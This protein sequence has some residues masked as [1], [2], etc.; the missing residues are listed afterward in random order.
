MVN[1][2]IDKG[3]TSLTLTGSLVDIVSELLYGIDITHQRMA[4]QNANAACEFEMLMKM[5]LLHVF[6][7]EE[8]DELVELVEL[9]EVAAKSEES[10]ED[11]GHCKT[12]IED[13]T[14]K[15]MEVVKKK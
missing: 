10:E 8:M 2:K 9:V 4:E 6:H 5:G 3:N 11:E 14:N 1:M 12:S 15:L 13:F 7:P